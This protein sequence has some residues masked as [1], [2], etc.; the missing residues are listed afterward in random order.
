MCACC[1]R[2]F[3][4]Q[5]GLGVQAAG[6]CDYISSRDAFPPDVCNSSSPWVVSQ[7]AA[8]SS[9]SARC[10]LSSALL[11]RLANSCL[12][13]L[14]AMLRFS[15]S[16]IAGCL[17][18]LYQ[19]V[20]SLSKCTALSRSCALGRSFAAFINVKDIRLLR[21]ATCAPFLAHLSCRLQTAAWRRLHSRLQR[22]RL[23]A[24]CGTSASATEDASRARLT[25]LLTSV[26][27]EVERVEL[28]CSSLLC[29]LQCNTTCSSVRSA[30]VQEVP[31][32]DCQCAG[33]PAQQRMCCGER[34]GR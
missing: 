26:S 20:P 6:E 3:L 8:L 9:W 14:L 19:R 29:C 4:Q 11:R 28:A 1:S 12:T 31:E 21:C 22:P 5:R 18:V 34:L 23:S 30:P 10:R 17:F 25:F 15:Q 24:G 33:V 2:S 27:T 16:N 32:G 7:A 13:A